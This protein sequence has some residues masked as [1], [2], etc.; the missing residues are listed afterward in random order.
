M[1]SPPSSAPPFAIYTRR[2]TGNE[3]LLY[4]QLP[5]QLAVFSFSV[6]ASTYESVKAYAA[7][8]RYNLDGFVGFSGGADILGVQIT[9]EADT[10]VSAADGE[11]LPYYGVEMTIEIRI[12]AIRT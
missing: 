12:R 7:A 11:L 9:S 2:S 1:L 8:V 4:G 5:Q 6:F 3:P 10:L